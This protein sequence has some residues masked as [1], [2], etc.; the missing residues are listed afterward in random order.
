MS[1]SNVNKINANYWITSTK[2]FHIHLIILFGLLVEDD[3]LS[4]FNLS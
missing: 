1:T 3:F 4:F 2:I